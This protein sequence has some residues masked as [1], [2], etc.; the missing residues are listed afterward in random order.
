MK[1]ILLTLTVVIF[2]TKT[3]IALDMQPSTSPTNLEYSYKAYKNKNHIY[4]A[5]IIA[6][7]CVL[8][9]SCLGVF[10]TV[11]GDKIIEI[12]TCYIDTQNQILKVHQESHNDLDKTY[13][14]WDIDNTKETATS[15]YINLKTNQEQTNS[16]KFLKDG[17]TIQSF[18]SLLPNIQL[19]PGYTF[20]FPLLVP[21][22]YFHYLTMTVIT[23]ESINTID[24]EIECY[25]LEL[26]I[27]GLFGMILPKCSFWV[28]KKPPH[29]PYKYEEPNTTYILDSYQIKEKKE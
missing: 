1:K 29:I 16:F 7:P 22:D 10:T 9:N 6:R 8:K 12:N 21:P 4:T 27:S 18:L 13:F 24:G 15:K 17:L 5:N 20:D 28:R 26:R 23:T 19:K 11:K 14:I 2:I 3:A 25:R